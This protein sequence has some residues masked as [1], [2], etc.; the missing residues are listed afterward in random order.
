MRTAFLPHATSKISEA[1][2]LTGIK[3]LGFRGEALPSIAAVSKVKLVTRTEGEDFACAIYGEGGVLGEVQT[4]AG[5]KGTSVTVSELF[6]ILPQDLNSLKSLR[7]K[8]EK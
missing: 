1:A 3:T 8:R 4:V 6:S 7:A 5:N 2:D